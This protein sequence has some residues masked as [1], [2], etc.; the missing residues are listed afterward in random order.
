MADTKQDVLE[1]LEELATLTTLDE[2]DV[3]SFKVRAYE[4]ASRGVE[5]YPGDIGKLSVAEL[6]KLDG[7]GKSTAAKI[8]ELIDGGRVAK[9]EE[10]RAKFPASVVGL[11]KVPGVGPKAVLKLRAEL[12]VQSVDD[13][14][15][16][17]AEQKLRGLKGFGAKTEEK[18]A[19]TLARM[20]ANGASRTPISV[21]LPLAERI[22]ASL[23]DV[24]GVT[25]AG[26]CGSLRRF[27]ETIGDIDVLCV[28][29]DPKP[30]MD[31]L[32][33]MSF[34]DRVIVRGDSKTSV[35]SRRGTQIDLRVVAAHQL[36]AA[37]LYFTGSKAHNI[38]LRMRAIAR[39][40]TL[41]EYALAEADGGKVI[42]SETEEAI[43]AALGLSFIPPVVRE[44]SG[45]IEL[46]EKGMLPREFGPILGDFH[47]HTT[48]SGDGRSPIE[49]V[50]AAARARGYRVLAITDHA[51]GTVSGVGRDALIEQRARIQELQ[52]QL[53]D[54]TLLHGA[55]LN[56]GAEG[57]LD[58]DAEFRAQFDF[59]L[60][61][62]HDHFDL[63]REQQTRRVVTA[64]RDPSVKMI[65]HL[66]A[67]MIGGRPGID[68]DID[69]I[70]AAAEETNTAL[71]INGGLPRLDVSVDVLRR[72]RD[73]KVNFVF[74]SDAHHASELERIRF[75]ALNAQRALLSPER[76]INTRDEAR[77]LSW[78]RKK[79]IEA[80]CHGP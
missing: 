29:A 47:V 4:S 27:S 48:V 42:A 22:V 41:N 52:R 20:D 26:Y 68:L 25:F 53:P 51:E 38:K 18:L 60:A 35:V 49:D 59:C 78:A 62:V 80:V 36:G 66:S 17:I 63:T 71:E 77:L 44:D 39:G 16:A 34:V 57:Q 46:A 45:E 6:Q 30:V 1:M 31:A 5:S 37:L 9:L 7:I 28:A 14:K 69:A 43:Y 40:W 70:F 15:K 3:Q 72:A 2:G 24:A 19:Q 75:A 33:A 11:M 12:G 13:L 50:I 67:R 32:V 58:Y 54:L 76:V 55:E 65:G 61:S 79:E 8:R 74:T 64:M 21:A 73:R 56:I 23:R 10:L